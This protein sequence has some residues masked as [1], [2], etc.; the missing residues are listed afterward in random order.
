MPGTGKWNH[1]AEPTTATVVGSGPNG[2]AAAVTLA[3]AGVEVL[4]LE[5]NP[6]AGG[7]ARSRSDLTVD[8]VLHDTCSASHPLGVAS[9]FL[10]SL[11][12][13]AHGLAWS[14]AAVELA[15][16]LDGGGGAALHRSV[17]RTA[18]GL[19]A[20]AGRWRALF[21]P[22]VEHL[23]DTLQDVLGPLVRVPRHPVGTAFFG[24]LALLP[25][26]SLARM[27]ADPTAASLFG[28]SAAHLMAPLA[29]P[30]SAAVGLL[31]TAAAQQSGWPVAV[32]GSGRITSAL[33]SVLEE[34]GGRVETGVRV[35]SIEDLPGGGIVML[36]TTPAAAVGLL[37]EHLP[38]RVARAYGR[39][40]HGPGAHKVD[41]AVESGIPWTY[42][43]ARRA[44]VVHLGGSVGEIVANEALVW[45]GRMP[46]RP[47]VLVGQ[48]YLADPDRSVGDIHPVWAYAHVPHGYTG[49]ATR[50]VLEQIER[51][52][53]G[54]R[55]RIVAVHSTSTAG[56]AAS[57][58]N[59]VGG[60]I[61]AG[62]N[63]PIQ[64]LTGPGR[65]LHPYDTG[66][67]GVY[68]CSASTPPGAGVHG[69]CG[70]LAALEALGDHGIPSAAASP[71]PSGPCHTG[72]R[73]SVRLAWHDRATKIH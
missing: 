35:R 22:I 53:P 46:D 2:L 72:R 7:G 55:D 11:D 38:T 26:T 41:L 34:L 61:A 63:S 47:F 28:G 58:P 30:T 16:P 5:A 13:G 62:A 33:I 4:V 56:L 52:A 15:H 31:L 71:A 19:G 49:D 6:D 20:A 1:T 14:H 57:N 51:F 60:D 37:G 42:E 36:D 66:V 43:P 50:E 54:V 39:W 70:H 3:L 68:L 65:L 17:E 27:L 45:R 59:Y 10:S 25:A 32:G 48:Q 21:G 44:G 12:L 24:G 73:C 67:P 18:G 23:D 40:R 9:P 8:G 69:M 29:R 64:L